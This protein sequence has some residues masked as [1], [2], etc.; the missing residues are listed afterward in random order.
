MHHSFSSVNSLRIIQWGVTLK[1]CHREMRLGLYTGSREAGDCSSKSVCRWSKFCLKLYRALECV[2][3]Y[4]HI[5]VAPMPYREWLAACCVRML[6]PLI[7]QRRRAKRDRNFFCNGPAAN[8]KTNSHH[9]GQFLKLRTKLYV[10]LFMDMPYSKREYSSYWFSCL[11]MWTSTADTR[12]LVWR[13][14]YEIIGKWLK[15]N[16]AK[17][18]LKT[19]LSGL[20]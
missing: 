7:V 16:Y 5:N 13:D 19:K 18:F 3:S 14:M 8:R 4:N 1:K 11:G 15:Q 2:F 20:Q 6:C 9:K 12:V 17:E 10:K